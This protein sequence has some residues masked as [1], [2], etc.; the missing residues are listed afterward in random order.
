[1][2][3]YTSAARMPFWKWL[4]CLIGGLVLFFVL[5]GLAEWAIPAIT[6]EWLRM[7]VCLG[8]GSIALFIYAVWTNLTEHRPITEL[9]LN[10]IWKDQALGLLLGVLYFG[11]VVGLMALA[12]SYTITSARFNLMPQLTAFMLFYVVAVFEEIIFRGVIFRLI[13]DRWNSALALIISAV[14]FGALHYWNPGASL[15]SSCAIAIEAG[16]LLGAAYKH[17]GTLWLPIG[18][19]WA[20]NYVQGNVLGFAV[21]GV[22]TSDKIFSPIITGSDWITGGAFGAEASVP[23]V[24]VGLLLTIVLLAGRKRDRR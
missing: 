16:L 11:A 5:Y 1:M 12:G 22:Q 20:W 4:L 6:N 9:D 7:V 15:W 10:R 21:S 2:R 8:I 18:I 3:K 14:L 13:D 19:H 17:F 23:A 24:G